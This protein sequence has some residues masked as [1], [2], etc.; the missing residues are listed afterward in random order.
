MMKG[1]SLPLRR[2]VAAVC[3]AGLLSVASLAL[4]QTSARI[5]S[6]Q[7]VL[8]GGE[9]VQIGS[10]AIDAEGKLSGEGVPQGLTLDDLRLI[11][12]PGETATP[13]PAAVVELRGG[14]R[15]L[16]QGVTIADD[17]CRIAWQHGE[18]LELPL[19]AV[20]AIR[21][22][23]ARPD[24]EFDKALAAP[25]PNADRVFVKVE[26][27]KLDRIAGLV[28][29]LTETALAIEISGQT[30]EIPRDK[31]YGIVVAQPAA[32]SAPPRCLVTLAGGSTLGGAS[33]ALAEGEATLD[34][35]AGAKA[36]FPWDAVR[37]VAIRS[38]RVAFLSDLKPV[39]E[40]QQPI[41][42]LPRP[43]QRDKSVSGGPLKIGDRVFEKGIGVHSRSLLT[44]EADGQYDVLAATIGLDAAA[45]GKGDCVF[46]VLADDEPLLTKR[47][48]GNDP[49]QTIELPI[50]G[51]RLITLLVEPGEGL[52]LADH[53]NWCEARF[54]KNR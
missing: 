29:G 46:V 41:L 36:Q 28:D 9:A 20:R 54:I 14:G 35:G 8:L 3:V 30:R 11:Q 38:N 51:R 4:S 18:L 42:T 27:D 52:D 39:V 40:E 26:E 23:P 17:K 49:P 19:D 48:R 45:G 5:T 16:A 13:K 34:L 12:L 53:A 33:L 32:E 24:A 47:M 15:V 44:F 31:V 22:E 7:L 2:I 1:M 50:S 10:L 6:P 21:L 37:S 43:W 25:D